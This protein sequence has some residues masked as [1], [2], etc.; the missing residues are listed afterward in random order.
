MFVK[1]YISNLVH[2]ELDTNDINKLTTKYFNLIR[3]N[4]HYAE[5][6][7]LPKLILR[8]NDVYNILK[9]MTIKS[10]DDKQF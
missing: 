10:N 1:Y 7:L 2:K 9:T 6:L 4:I 5:I 3:K 8:T